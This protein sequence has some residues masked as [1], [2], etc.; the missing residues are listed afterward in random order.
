MDKIDFQNLPSTTTPVN[1]TNLNQMQENMDDVDVLRQGK[2]SIASNSDLNSITTVGTYR[3]DSGTVTNSLSNCPITGT[4]FKMIVEKL[5]STESNRIRQTIYQHAVGSKTW[6]R[7]CASGTWG[8]WLPMMDDSGT[9]TPT[10]ENATL[11]Y[12]TRGGNYH[13]IGNVLFY[14][15][16]VRGNITAITGDE[17]AYITGL[18]LHAQYASGGGSVKEYS[19]IVVADDNPPAILIAYDSTKGTYISLQNT[20]T[21]KGTSTTKWKTTGSGNTFYFSCTGFYFLA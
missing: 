12:T 17:Y 4:A 10:I 19:N 7:T 5:H 3:S 2:T 16:Q 8:E 1:A 14:S 20:S 9:W 6:V 21:G 15:C 11:T 18:P 13:R